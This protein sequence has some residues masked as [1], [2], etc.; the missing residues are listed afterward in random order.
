MIFINFKVKRFW[1]AAAATVIF[2][3]RWE[4]KE[5]AVARLAPDPLN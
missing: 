5:Q 2:K 3:M 1:P 4:I